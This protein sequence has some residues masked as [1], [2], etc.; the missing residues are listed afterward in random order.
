MSAVIEVRIDVT[1]P[2]SIAAA[3][4]R[5]ADTTLLINNAG[6]AR[7]NAGSLDP[8]VADLSR[9][10]FETNYYG[11]IGVCQAFAPVISGNGGGAVINVLSDAVWLTRPA[12]AAYSASKA[13]LW[14]LTNA[15]RS[16]LRG[17]NTV[18]QG[19]HVSFIDT[20]MTSGLEI[21][22]ISPRLVVEA[23]LDGIEA[24][25]EEVLVGESTNKLKQGLSDERAIY[26]D[27]PAIA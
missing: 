27:P 17:Q 18:V 25:K 22:K 3:A 15:L 2:T 23:A 16:D 14:S 10:I 5:C 1:D 4:A 20:D 12:L 24:G 7:L 6:I 8:L 21:E 11:A 13:A 9:E 26:L 19:L